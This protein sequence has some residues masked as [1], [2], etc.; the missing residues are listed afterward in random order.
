MTEEESSDD[1]KCCMEDNYENDTRLRIQYGLKNTDSEII[2]NTRRMIVQI[3]IIVL[4]KAR[5]L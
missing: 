5:L 1:K 2:L 3:V 4:M